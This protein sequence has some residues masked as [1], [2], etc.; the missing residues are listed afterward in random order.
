MKGEKVKAVVDVKLNLDFA[1][2][3]L[4]YDYIEEDVQ[5]LSLMKRFAEAQDVRVVKALAAEM[6]DRFGSLPDEAK[7][8]VRIAEL[9]VLCAAASIDHLDVKGSRAVF[10][11][12]GARDVFR[13]IDLRG[14]TSASKLAELKAAVS[15]FA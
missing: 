7:E 6:K 14:K 1:N 12:T 10:Y 4:P 13:V 9:R 5:R 11:K 2:P 8:F 15:S 3:R